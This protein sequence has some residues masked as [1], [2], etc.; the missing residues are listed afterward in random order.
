[1]SPGYNKNIV[2][3]GIVLSSLDKSEISFILR[4]RGYRKYA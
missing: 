3:N 1:M 4:Y 2:L